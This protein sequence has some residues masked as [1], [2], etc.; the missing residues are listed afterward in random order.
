MLKY[1]TVTYNK[2]VV[3]KS[4]VLVYDTIDQVTLDA[5]AVELHPFGT[6]LCLRIDHSQFKYHPLAHKQLKLLDSQPI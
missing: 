3:H 4:V 2:L 5:I 1:V 6:D